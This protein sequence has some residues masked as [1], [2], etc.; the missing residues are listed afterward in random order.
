MT[1]FLK[2]EN[3]PYHYKGPDQIY[4]GKININFFKKLAEPDSNGEPISAMS[5][6]GG[7]RIMFTPTQPI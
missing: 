4:E 5:R 7:S 3:N 1:Y 6:Q 2:I